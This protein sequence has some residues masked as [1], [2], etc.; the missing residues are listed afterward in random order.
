[1]L[2]V[3]SHSGIAFRE[4]G[5]GA[6]LALQ[7]LGKGEAGEKEFSAM[8]VLRSSKRELLCKKLRNELVMPKN[9]GW[10]A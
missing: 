7:A 10:V 2:K 5:R 4:C 3:T 8:S 9:L 6:R 1:M